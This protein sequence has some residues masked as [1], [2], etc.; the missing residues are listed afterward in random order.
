MNYKS[1]NLLKKVN[2]IIDK[3]IDLVFYIPRHLYKNNMT[4]KKLIN[5]LEN[6]SDI[7]RERR[8]IAKN[9]FYYL[10][11]NE[12]CEVL[13]RIQLDDEDFY[14][15]FYSSNAKLLLEDKKWIAKNKLTVVETTLFDYV[16]E[17]TPELLYYVNDWEK[18]TKIYI[19]TK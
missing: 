12:K 8:R 15:D 17:D 4:F 14:F 18:E 16:K 1:Y 3:L 13:A 9:I 2:K 7:R 11:K 5:N 6:N 19:V 10:N